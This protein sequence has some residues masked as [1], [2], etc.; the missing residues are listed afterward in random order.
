VYH[1]VGDSLLIQSGGKPVP[2][3]ADPERFQASAN[4]SWESTREFQHPGWHYFEDVKTT[5]QT[6]Q[7]YEAV[8]AATELGD[9]PI[10]MRALIPAGLA[11]EMTQVQGPPSKG[12]P[13]GYRKK[14]LP[15]F[16]MRHKGKA[17]DNPFV[18]VYESYGEEPSVRSVERLM[19]GN[20][21]KGTKITSI[22][23]GQDLT[24]YIL[25]QEKPDDIYE[26]RETGIAFTGQFG[27]VAVDQHG[28]LRELYIGDGEQ[29][30]F[31]TTVLTTPKGTRAAYRR[32][33]K[34][35]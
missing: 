9:A 28:S 26:D 5:R 27:V 21:F 29:L 23:D 22:V 4:T 11:T 25:L 19:S 7:G 2:M 35:W 33:S 3:T 8:F 24:H 6:N 16:V 17:W 30:A 13:E 10:H 31:G 18:A 20:V 32:L 15:A 12:A 34:T 1:N 14:P